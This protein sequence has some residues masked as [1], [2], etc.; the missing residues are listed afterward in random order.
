[1][2]ITINRE[3][4]SGAAGNNASASAAFPGQSEVTGLNIKV[5]GT[6]TID[7]N[8]TFTNCKVFFAVDADMVTSGQVDLVG[9]ESE[10]APCENHTWK[11][12]TINHAAAIQFQRC[13]IWGADNGL[14]FKSGYRTSASLLIENSFRRNR[15][16]IL[17]TDASA[18]LKFS[19][20]Y[21][22]LF[23]GAGTI[24][25][26]SET[27]RTG[28]SVANCTAVIGTTFVYDPNDEEDG[29]YW[30]WVNQFINFQFGIETDKATVFV[31]NCSFKNMRPTPEMGVPTGCGIRAKNKST[32]ITGG[33]ISGGVRF[34]HCE[35]ESCALAGIHATA[36][37][38]TI[39]Y[40]QFRGTTLYGIRSTDTKERGQFVSGCRF[41]M[42]ASS[43]K[44]GIYVERPSNP[45]SVRI[46][47]D[48][49]NIINPGSSAQLSG[50]DLRCPYPATN[51]AR[52]NNNQV[53]ETG[54]SDISFGI[55]AYGNQTNNLLIE[56]NRC[57]SDGGAGDDFGIFLTDCSGI[58]HQLR[59]NK[60]LGGHQCNFHIQKSLNATYCNNT[61]GGGSNG[62][63]FQG[64]NTGTVWSVNHINAHAFGLLIEDIPGSA[65]R[66]GLQTRK[67]NM[68][69]EDDA[70]YSSF[71][72]KC[73]ASPAQSAFIVEQENNKVIFPTKTQPQTGWFTFLEGPLEH[74]IPGSMPISEFERQYAG[75]Q[76]PSGYLSAAESWEVGRGLMKTLIQTPSAMTNEPVLQTFYN[77]QLNTSTGQAALLEVLMESTPYLS[78]AQLTQLE[79]LYTQRDA[80][81]TEIE[82][83]NQGNTAPDLSNGFYNGGSNPVL[84]AKVLQMQSITTDIA[85]LL[86]AIEP[87]WTSH[88]QTSLNQLQSMS[89]GQTYEQA[90]KTLKTWE[91]KTQLG[92]SAASAGYADMINLA[93]SN[94]L[95]SGAAVRHA[96]QYMPECERYPLIASTEFGA[97]GN[98]IKWQENTAGEA[99]VPMM[100]QPNPTTGEIRVVLDQELSGR[101]T[102]SS[103]AGALVQS[104]NWPPGK[105]LTID[106]RPVPDGIY[107][108]VLSSEKGITLTQKV[109]IK[110]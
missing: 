10:F 67:G 87:G 54:T 1:M 97:A 90:W 39:R 9:Y 64:G 46:T 85:N 49:I 73:D 104:G 110:H 22:N 47:Y 51:Q 82:A 8:F 14:T 24:P 69:L 48:T 38:T 86:A 83:L 30:W 74:C 65:G 25:G 78:A 32:L 28:I 41:T 62:F 15:N 43:N 23:S 57:N 102:L 16:G 34:G 61:S 29:Y 109:A 19:S 20:F 94:P 55:I 99:P 52:I 101:W 3:V 105:Q 59:D 53:D 76:L 79:S 89:V 68:W 2:N 7:K 21:Q 107:I 66:I 26:S 4:G 60:C 11:G 81:Q 58:G 103:S 70:Q 84:D 17:C 71:A 35:F 77:Q 93:Y 33:T 5:V 63:H 6:F 37:T 100:I 27:P 96:W 75:G 56:N 31:Y 88:L 95:N 92:Y 13:S 80:L 72:A 12:I 108:L 98:R 106:L 50:I 45:A 36:S 91:L 18:T 44:S 42:N 40:A